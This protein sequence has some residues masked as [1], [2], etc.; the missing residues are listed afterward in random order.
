MNPEILVELYN[1]NS[2]FD[3][4]IWLLVGILG[5]LIVQVAFRL[6]DGWKVRSNDVFRNTMENY[7]NRGEF[8]VVTHGCDMKISR[9]PN[10]SQAYWLKGKSHFKLGEYKEAEDAFN[11]LAALEP[12]WHRSVT[13]WLE[14][15]KGITQP[16]DPNPTE[17]QPED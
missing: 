4:I 12:G 14:H 10:D 13:P 7:F 2:K 5:I 11:Q 6:H 17:S 1:L 9:H 8:S 3:R 15:I 16:V